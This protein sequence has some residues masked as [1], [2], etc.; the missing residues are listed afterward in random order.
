GR[1]TTTPTPHHTDKLAELP[2]AQP[3]EQTYPPRL[4]RR[5]HSTHTEIITCLTRA[6]GTSFNGEVRLEY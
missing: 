1:R 4:R 2:L 3:R 6:Y 5:D